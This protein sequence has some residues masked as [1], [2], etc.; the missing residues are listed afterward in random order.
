MFQVRAGELLNAISIAGRYNYRHCRTLG[1]LM[2]STTAGNS[3]GW[4]QFVMQGPRFLLP[5]F[6]I[7]KI[8]GSFCRFPFGRVKTIADLR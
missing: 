2:E 5:I 1:A 8:P 3:A 7:R 4:D 6:I